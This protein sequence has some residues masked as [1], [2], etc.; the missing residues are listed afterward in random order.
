MTGQ[1]I[2]PLLECGIGGALAALRLRLAENGFAHGMMNADAM[3][4][5]AA[6]FPEDRRAMLVR[7]LQDQSGPDCSTVHRELLRRLARPD[8]V[9]AV[10]GQQ[11]VSALGP[12]YVHSKIAETV[13]LAAHWT[14]EGVNTVPV[15]WMASED[16]DID[17]VRRIFW[18]GK[19]VAAWDRPKDPIR[20]GLVEA[21]PVA[22]AIKTWLDS[23]PVPES[24][25]M[26]AER[27]EEAYRN[28]ANLAEASRRLLAHYHP[29]ILVLDGS[30]PRLKA[31]AGALWQDE[32]ANQTLFRTA[33]EASKPWAGADP[34]VPFRQSALFALDRQGKRLRID[35][36]A[37]GSWIRSDGFALGSDRD[38]AAWA[39][40]NPQEVSPN[41]LLRL[42]YQE[43]IMPNAAYT[44]GAAE[45]AYA[46]QLAPYWRNSGSPHALWRL[47]HS[48]AWYAAK[49]QK[50]SQKF[51]SDFFRGSWNPQKVRQDIL[52]EAGAPNRKILLLTEEFKAKITERYG[53]PG[54]EQSVAAW[55][56][57]IANEEGKMLERLRREIARGQSNR[58][59]DLATLSDS[60]MPS[61]TLQERIWTHFD[62]AEYA[63]DDALGEYLKAF[64][65]TQ[66]WDQAG[67]WE[68]R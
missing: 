11:L 6:A 25:R 39:S 16:H 66:N 29:E 23:A 44:G 21:L 26:A 9:T 30:D 49:A 27:S 40:S 15:F 57:R 34:P 67:W 62:L 37:Q 24:V 28:S 61:G 36:N 22:E 31:V 54:L 43:W 45:V 32:I 68:F 1:W 65:S 42:A 10:A 60:L 63:G 12:L 17:E 50:A 2:A 59:K 3:R 8:S 56:K 7:V 5:R 55:V 13:A 51:N 4:R 38:V 18:R 35:R 64:S 19:A 46:Q 20:S 52:E 41:A 53:M 14:A 48:S 47:R 58:L 33:E